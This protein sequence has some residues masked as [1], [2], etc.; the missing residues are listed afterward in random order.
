M[1]AVVRRNLLVRLRSSFLR[2][3]C[4][5]LEEGEGGITS[6]RFGLAISLRKLKSNKFEMCPVGALYIFANLCHFNTI[7]I[8]KVPLSFPRHVSFG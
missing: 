7:I 3:V 1:A 4:R 6:I 8:L 2:H 5:Y